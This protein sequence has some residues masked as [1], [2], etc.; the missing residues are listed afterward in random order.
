M[1]R[2][3]KQPFPDYKEFTMTEVKDIVKKFDEDIEY[4]E[5]KLENCKDRGHDCSRLSLQLKT[6]KDVQQIMGE[7][8]E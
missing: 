1:C 8:Y 7:F 2:S 3:G 4:F 5:A 6:F